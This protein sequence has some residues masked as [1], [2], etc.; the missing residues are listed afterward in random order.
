MSGQEKDLDGFL[1]EYQVLCE[2][3]GLVMTYNGDDGEMIVE[4]VWFPRGT[5]TQPLPPFTLQE[6]IE[7]IRIRGV[8]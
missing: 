4:T 2:K 6:H 3:Y 1:R 7:D 8:W 5:P